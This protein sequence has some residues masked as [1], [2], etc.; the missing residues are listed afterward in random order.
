MA[1]ILTELKYLSTS[2]KG[3]NGEAELSTTEA[4]QAQSE[5]KEIMEDWGIRKS[6]L[7]PRCTPGVFTSL[8]EILALA[9]SVTRPTG[10]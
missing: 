9:I 7:G 5:L 3:A 2:R 6:Y 4:A 8:L 1:G 10:T